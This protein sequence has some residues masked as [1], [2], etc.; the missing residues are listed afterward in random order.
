LRTKVRTG[1]AAK[2]RIVVLEGLTEK[3]TVVRHGVQYVEGKYL[4]AAE[5]TGIG[6]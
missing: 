3:A 6:H 2:G 5:D 4:S 1:L